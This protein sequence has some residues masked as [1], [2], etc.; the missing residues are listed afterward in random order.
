MLA[1]PLPRLRVL[2]ANAAKRSTS[3]ALLT[4]TGNRI[5]GIVGK[6]SG[7]EDPPHLLVRH[8]NRGILVRLK[9]LE[10]VLEASDRLVRLKMITIVSS[11]N[12]I[13][14]GWTRVKVNRAAWALDRRGM[15]TIDVLSIHG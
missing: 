14:K 10:E 9:L 2:L 15:A 7:V 5:L 11:L 12:V 3:Q 8:F 6:Q 1:D 4:G 13:S